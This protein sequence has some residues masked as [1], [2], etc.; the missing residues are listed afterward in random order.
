MLGW[1]RRRW[2]AVCLPVLLFAVP[3]LGIA[4]VLAVSPS[5]FS[6]YLH[7]PG[8]AVGAGAVV[9]YVLAAG[10][11][12]RVARSAWRRPWHVRLEH[13]CDG[14]PGLAGLAVEVARDGGRTRRVQ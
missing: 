1:W 11:A 13:R 2:L 8:A 9:L 12:V 4:V 3:L 5:Y 6:P 14:E 7:W 10:F